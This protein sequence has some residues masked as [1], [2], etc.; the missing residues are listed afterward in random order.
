[1]LSD[2]ERF[3]LVELTAR[4]GE[5]EADRTWHRFSISLPLHAGLIAIVTYALS[6]NLMTFTVIL[7][8]LGTAMAILWY[9][10][11]VFSQ[12]AEARWR[13]DMTRLIN[14]DPTLK[15]ALRSRSSAGPDLK[16]PRWSSTD[17]AKA[18]VCVVGTFWIVVAVYALLV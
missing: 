5:Q 1:V 3:R 12:F 10:I 13:S 11:M 15:A 14:E 7:A 8:A 9:R 6:K 4:L 18:M 2:E 16:R 17:N